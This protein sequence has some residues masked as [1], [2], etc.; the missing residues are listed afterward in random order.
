MDD[1]FHW[2][3]FIQQSQ[4]CQIDRPSYFHFFM[5]VFSLAICYPKDSG[6]HPK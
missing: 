4:L 6:E 5:I 1:E 3:S 2:Y